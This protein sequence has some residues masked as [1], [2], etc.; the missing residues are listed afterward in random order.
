MT[1]GSH[2]EVETRNRIKIAVYA[3]AYEFCD[4]PLVSD[5]VFDELAKSIDKNIKT[6]NKPID[7]FF[8]KKFET[9]TG[10]WIHHH[11][12]LI[13]IDALYH[14]HYRSRH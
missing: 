2:V 3:Y 10:S 4:D 8:C 13:K 7:D 5:A 14:K 6:G 9:F 11:P 12:E 1:W